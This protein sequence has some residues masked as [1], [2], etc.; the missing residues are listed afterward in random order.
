M[1]QIPL[2]VVTKR[3]EDAVRALWKRGPEAIGSVGQKR[4]I[5][6]NRVVIAGT[7]VPVASVKAFAAAGFSVDQIRR[8]Y[9]GLT[10]A[11]IRAALAY[12]EAA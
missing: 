10:E 9:P 11:D 5:V 3:L 8:E 7:R 1:L 12:G 6:R 4:G 2:P